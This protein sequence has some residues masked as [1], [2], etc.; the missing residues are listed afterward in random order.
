M[1]SDRVPA[2]AL[3]IQLLSLSHL[4]LCLPPTPPQKKVSLWMIP[5]GL[6]S[7]EMTWPLLCDKSS[8]APENT[9]EGYKFQQKQSRAHWQ[10]TPLP[11]ILL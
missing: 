9:S 4:Y 5:N 2:S 11:F 8:A 1:R 6:R 7:T 10:K 3:P